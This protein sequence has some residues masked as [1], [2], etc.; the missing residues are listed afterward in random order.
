MPKVIIKVTLN[1]VPIVDVVTP[2]VMYGDTKL[3]KS[4][5]AYLTKNFILPR[6]VP[7]DE[8]LSEAKELIENR[9]SHNKLIVYLESQFG[10]II[11]SK[12]LPEIATD[13]MELLNENM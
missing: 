4:L 10:P 12:Y 6:S 11:Q 1:G 3:E 9:F 13:I 7:A 8:C 5:N 2:E